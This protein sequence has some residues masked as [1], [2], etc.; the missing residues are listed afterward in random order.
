MTILEFWPDYAGTLL[1][2]A[3]GARLSLD[4]V[5]LPAELIDRARRWVAEYDD[6]KLPWEPT[7]DDQWLSDGTRPFDDLRRELLE[8]GFDLQPAEDFWV[9]PG[10]G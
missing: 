1:W 8:H 3:D 10:P 4:D 6:S 5:P 2:T 7:R 9:P